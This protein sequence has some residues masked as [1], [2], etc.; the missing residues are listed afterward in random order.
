MNRKVRRF[1]LTV[2]EN[3]GGGEVGEAEHHHGGFAFALGSF[4]PG[5]VDERLIGRTE[6][7]TDVAH[8]GRLCR[9]CG[10]KGCARKSVGSQSVNTP[11]SWA[12]PTTLF[13]ICWNLSPKYWN[14][15][16]LDR[17]SP[18]KNRAQKAD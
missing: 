1:F 2:D 9:M 7:L 10:A 4:L 6:K 14:L 8:G 16:N 17:R 12:S 15:W 18:E 13:S 5:I 11:F 3:A